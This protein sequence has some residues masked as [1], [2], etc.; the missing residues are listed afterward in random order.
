MTRKKVYSEA[1]L[2]WSALSNELKT[3]CSEVNASLENDSIVG[4]SL[5]LYSDT[6]YFRKDK[7]AK[8]A[9]CCFCLYVDDKHKRRLLGK[10]GAHATVASLKTSDEYGDPTHAVVP[11]DAPQF[12]GLL[13]QFQHTNSEY[14]PNAPKMT[15]E[16]RL[17]RL[18]SVTASALLP[19]RILLPSYLCQYG[20]IKAVLEIYAAK[21]G[22]LDPRAEKTLRACVSDLKRYIERNVRQLSLN[23]LSHL[24]R[25]LLSADTLKERLKNINRAAA[26]ATSWV[27]DLP[28][29]D[30]IPRG[31]Y[32]HLRQYFHRAYPGLK[33]ILQMVSNAG[34]RRE[35]EHL[36]T[37]RRRPLPLG[38]WEHLRNQ[39]KKEACSDKKGSIS[40]AVFV[41]AYCRHLITQGDQTKPLETRIAEATVVE[42]VKGEYAIVGSRGDTRSQMTLPILDGSGRPLGTLNINSDRYAWIN[43]LWLATAVELAKFAAL[44]IEQESGYGLVRRERLTI[45]VPE[46]D[47]SEDLAKS[48]GAPIGL[49]EL[50][51]DP[52]DPSSLM[53]GQQ[54]GMQP[55]FFSRL[56]ELYANEVIYQKVGLEP[57]PG[58]SLTTKTYKVEIHDRYDT[59][60]TDPINRHVVRFFPKIENAESELQAYDLYV[61]PYLSPRFYCA[62]L[63]SKRNGRSA[64]ISYAWA[65][66]R[67]DDGVQTFDKKIRH[68]YEQCCRYADSGDVDGGTTEDLKFLD[69]SIATLFRAALD[70]WHS[71]GP[72]AFKYSGIPSPS[73]TAFY[74]KETAQL[75]LPPDSLSDADMLD[76]Q[77]VGLYELH[78][79]RKKAESYGP[80]SLALLREYERL[81]ERVAEA[82]GVPT[83]GICHGDLNPRNI[84][85]AKEHDDPSELWIIDFDRVHRG[86]VYQDFARLETYIVDLFVN[87]VVKEGTPDDK[88]DLWRKHLHVADKALAD[89]PGKVYRLR[90]KSYLLVLKRGG[91]QRPMWLKYLLSLIASVRQYAYFLSKWKYGQKENNYR[92][93]Y[94][95]ALLSQYLDWISH[96]PSGELKGK[97]EK[98]SK[99][100]ERLSVVGNWMAVA[101]LEETLKEF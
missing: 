44:V 34:Y 63:D 51:I 80:Q 97:E 11:L 15:T 74:E 5:L 65:A 31:S 75:S 47:L 33:G 1:G 30:S 61:Q 89:V 40:L 49:R 48:V 12:A 70:P 42:M 56:L 73:L 68:R 101:R 41:D 76:M 58:Y 94:Y 14:S 99:N 6:V 82:A 8:P 85:V 32:S 39:I 22:T 84:L 2:T 91:D 35:A 36:E 90:D 38:T 13:E 92:L 86:H 37:G 78:K 27:S 66:H 55:D 28:D 100:C 88:L 64:V 9:L 79:V 26:R 18:K 54:Y 98:H 71:S 96:D 50:T 23:V 59:D 43:P 57:L 20:T 19:F 29:D 83:L 52:V 77:V 24:S 4:A 81:K 53:Q 3:T 93:E 95:F 45:A 62:K 67:P 87:K 7:K 21:T 16:L 69:G 60:R 46:R 72:G 25:R 10:T 17:L